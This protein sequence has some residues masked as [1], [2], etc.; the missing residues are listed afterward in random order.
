MATAKSKS[1]RLG[2][3]TKG[4]ADIQTA[5]KNNATS[6]KDNV[7]NGA[8]NLAVATGNGILNISWNGVKYLGNK[9]IDLVK[10]ANNKIESNPTAKQVKDLTTGTLSLAAKGLVL[11]GV[12]LIMT[13][14]LFDTVVRG[15]FGLE[16]VAAE[17]VKN[18][19]NKPKKST[20]IDLTLEGEVSSPSKA[21]THRRQLE[22]NAASKLISSETSQKKS[23]RKKRRGPK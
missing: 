2:A 23:Q 8:S 5:V 3:M 21:I 9:G 11:A 22:R 19:S 16:S 6:L 1:T 15:I 10:L 18:K 20:T 4:L 14:E 12:S 17:K 7:V 13:V